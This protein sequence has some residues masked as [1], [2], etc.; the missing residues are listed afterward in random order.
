M[1]SVLVHS[2]ETNADQNGKLLDEK[3]I[4]RFL[5]GLIRSQSRKAIA[6]YI[7]GLKPGTAFQTGKVV[8]A[9]GMNK[10][11]VI[12]AL[13]DFASA[14]K[15]DREK[16]DASGIWTFRAVAPVE[17]RPIPPKRSKGPSEIIHDFLDTLAVGQ[18][19]TMDDLHKLDAGIGSNG[20][21][22]TLAA[23]TKRGLVVVTRKEGRMGMGGLRNVYIK[24]GPNSSTEDHIAPPVP[25]IPTQRTETP[26]EATPE[27]EE[28]DDGQNV[29]PT[30]FIPPTGDWFAFATFENGVYV[31]TELLRDGRTIVWVKKS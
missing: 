1:T 24:P 27:P 18:E 8:K 29:F 3:S 30:Q 20:Y 2:T 31:D 25:L 17:T 5:N 21:S 19:F 9:T 14:G 10:T 11:Q 13:H 12:R 28:E 4:D 16:D 15:I 23:F 6:E 22:A 26:P 7:L